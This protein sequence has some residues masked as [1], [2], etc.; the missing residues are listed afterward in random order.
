MPRLDLRALRKP[1]CRCNNSSPRY[2]RENHYAISCTDSWISYVHKSQDKHNASYSFQNVVER[3]KPFRLQIYKKTMKRLIPRGR[4]SPGT[5]IFR[6]DIERIDHK[7]ASTE[8]EKTRRIRRCGVRT[9]FL[10]RKRLRWWRRTPRVFAAIKLQ[11]AKG[12][13]TCLVVIAERV[14]R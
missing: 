4:K 9:V 2:T 6:S 3:Q 14:L 8:R 7:V 1:M 12:S 11:R 10:L 5:E 13:P